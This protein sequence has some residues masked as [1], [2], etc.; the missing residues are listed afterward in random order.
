MENN[1]IKDRMDDKATS[2]FMLYAVAVIKSR[3]IPMGEDGLKPVNRRILYEMGQMKIWNNSKTV[4]SAKVVGSVMGSLHPHGDASIYNAMVRLSQPWKMRYPL[5]EIQGNNGSVNGDPAAASRYTEAKLSA[6]GQLMLEGVDPDVVPFVPNFDETLLEPVILP[7]KFPNILCNGNDGIAVGMSC[8]TMPHNLNEVVNLLKATIDNSNLTVEEAMT[9]LHGPDFPLGGTIIN[10]YKLPEIYKTGR[11][12]IILQANSEIDYGKKRITFTN[13]PYLV[14]VMKIIKS[15][16]KMVIEDNDPDIEDLENNVG[17]GY[18]TI[19][20][21]KK[22]NPDA[23]LKRLYEQTPLQ[24]TIK[25]NQTIISGGVPMTLS[26]LGLVR[27]YLSQQH[28]VLMNAAAKEQGKQ[29]HIAHIQ[30]GL[31]LA[32][33]KIEEVIKI[34]RNSDDKDIAKSSIIELLG[35]D[36][37][38]ADAILALKLSSLTRLDVNNINVKI[39]NAEKE[40]LYQASIIQ[41]KNVRNNLIKNS[42]TAMASKY[43][44]SRRTKIIIGSEEAVAERA[45]P[46]PS[47][48]TLFED[49]EITKTP[50]EQF[51]EVSKKTKSNPV[52]W[53]YD[54]GFNS[55][56]L[57]KDGSTSE[58]YSSS[59]SNQFLFIWD[60]TK[61]YIV[62]ISKGGVVKKSQMSQYKN[63]KKL[64]KPKKDDSIIRAYCVDDDDILILLLE[65]QK[66][67]VVKVKDID[68]TDKLTVGKKQTVVG[69]T[70]A[71][72][73]S[74]NGTYFT[75]NES[76][77]VKQGSCE[78][79]AE[80]NGAVA[81]NESVAIGSCHDNMFYKSGTKVESVDWRAIP[82]K[83]KSAVGAKINSKSIN[84]VG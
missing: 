12:T 5:V 63:I 82:V 11:G 18:L 33:V 61:D 50:I 36:E 83:G 43:G 8:G 17:A 25:V 14:D 22:A 62:T 76:G 2:D 15:V 24:K 66:V 71:T 64:C 65:N 20:L 9:Y 67:N 1:I 35:I 60:D 51:I 80:H 13:F 53:T 21:N 56:V 27:Q 10:G 79:L 38:Q 73:A 30:K 32:T 55:A 40:S 45:K 49:G 74:Q 34:I 72:A 16:K 58:I 52:F 41:D 42:L 6:I 31:R 46:I 47:M 3:A 26:L 77:Q 44:D 28:T 59:E 68:T 29:D 78:E 19:I 37:M 4:K 39:D 23:V 75:L 84:Y 57:N 70:D 48:L 7:S 81:I 69:V 54:K